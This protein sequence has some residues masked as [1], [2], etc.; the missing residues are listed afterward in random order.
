M[1]LGFVGTGTM[2]TPIA[3]CL[4]DAGHR[5]TVYDVRPEATAALGAR[6]AVLAANPRAV[7][8]K[9]EIVFTSLPGPD[10]MEPAVLDPSTG[11]LAGL[12]A[13]GGYVDLTR[14]LPRW[15]AGWPRRAMPAASTCS[16][17]RSADGLPA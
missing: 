7:A 16:M 13:G 5:L 17:R 15:R 2:G 10:E 12:R 9:S 1:Q 4:I 8:E 6:G 14:T 11:I 3:G